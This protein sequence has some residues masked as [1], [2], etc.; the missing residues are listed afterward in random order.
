MLFDVD[1]ASK[2]VFLS[3]LRFT[4]RV[5]KCFFTVDENANIDK[6]LVVT[7]EVGLCT[8]NTA[9]IMIKSTRVEGLSELAELAKMLGSR[10][11]CL[12]SRAIKVKSSIYVEL[13][14]GGTIYRAAPGRGVRGAA[15]STMVATSRTSHLHPI[16]HHT[17]Y[18]SCD[19]TASHHG[20]SPTLTSFLT[21]SL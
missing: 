14:A 10:R 1:E 12:I 11:W 4:L 2:K 21:D 9:E 19:Y 7:E 15:A 5:I 20:I 18:I 13:W 16:H 17:I 3:R 8:S 6:I